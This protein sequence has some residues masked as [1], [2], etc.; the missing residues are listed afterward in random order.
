MDHYQ[1]ICNGYDSLNWRD[2]INMQSVW[3]TYIDASISSTVNLP[4]EISI[5]ETMDLYHYAWEK[6]LKG[7]TIFRDKCKRAGI[8]T[9][10]EP[11]EEDLK[12]TDEDVEEINQDLKNSKLE[13]VRATG[14]YSTCPDCKSED[15]IISA[16]CVVC[17]DCGFSPC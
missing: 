11:E 4:K 2:R 7:A 16:G 10:D 1:I 13:E 6:G 9:L 12:L 3:Q 5:E 8:L 14:Y 17:R 15:M